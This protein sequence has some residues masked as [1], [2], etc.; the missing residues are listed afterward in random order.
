M[1]DFFIE[2]FNIYVHFAWQAWML[3]GSSVAAV[4][5]AVYEHLD[6]DEAVSD[7]HRLGHVDRGEDAA[8]VQAQLV[9]RAVG[10]AQRHH[11]LGR[12]VACKIN[13]YNIQY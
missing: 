6:V 9:H 11:L 13:K 1:R 5:E 10:G 4:L 7:V 12:E 8:R 3:V 2:Y